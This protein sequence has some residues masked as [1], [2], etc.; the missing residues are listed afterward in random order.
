MLLQHF[1]QYFFF[2]VKKHRTW[3][4]GLKVLSYLNLPTVMNNLYMTLKTDV[5]II[6]LCK[7]NLFAVVPALLIRFYDCGSQ[8]C[9]LTLIRCK[10]DFFGYSTDLLL[11]S[12]GHVI[13]FF[14]NGDCYCY[15]FM[16]PV[17]KV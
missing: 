17:L 5:V 9:V 4:L 6:L 13:H 3:S 11:C 2:L 16:G 1:V 14:L 15:G 7:Q 12:A 8:K 10:F